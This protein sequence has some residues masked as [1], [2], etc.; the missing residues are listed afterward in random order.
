MFY[1][2][3]QRTVM[4][5]VLHVYFEPLCRLGT[6]CENPFR[7]PLARGQMSGPLMGLCLGTPRLA[8]CS[9]AAE[10][11][12]L[13]ESSETSNLRAG[14]AHRCQLPGLRDE[15]FD[16]QRNEVTC[17]RTHPWSAAEPCLKPRISGHEFSVLFTTTS[18]EEKTFFSSNL[19]FQL[20]TLPSHFL[21]FKNTHKPDHMHE[22]LSK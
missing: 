10:L 15:E 22:E 21:V 17:P 6:Q 18:R 5:P 11:L 14:R 4:E 8:A 13:K 16:V 19:R 12:T 2:E 3:C 7:L 9:P 1:Q 20:Y